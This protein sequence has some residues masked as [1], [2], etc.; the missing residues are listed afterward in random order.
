M[1]TTQ[2]VIEKIQDII[3]T[4]IAY[5]MGDPESAAC[6]ATLQKNPQTYQRKEAVLYY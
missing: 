6:Y 3:D 2:E 4:W 5:V 1:A